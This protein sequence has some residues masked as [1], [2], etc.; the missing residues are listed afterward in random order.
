MPFNKTRSAGVYAKEILRVVNGAEL[1]ENAVVD[2][3]QIPLNADQRRILETGTVMIWTGAPGTSK[4]RP[5]PTSAPSNVNEVQTI[6][7]SA[8]ADAGAVKIKVPNYGTT[9]SIPFGSVT[10]AGLQAAIRA[11][12][13]GLNAMT[14]G[15]VSDTFTLTFPNLDIEPVSV[16][17]NTLKASSVNVTLTVGQGAQGSAALT[18]AA[19]AGI[20]MHT[21]EF[22]PGPDSDMDEKDDAPVALFTK[23][24]HFAADQLTGYANNS[25]VVKSAMTGAGND[26]CANCTF[27]S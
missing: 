26:R 20:V 21:T 24:C 9:A 3:N 11:I 1:A 19:I 8:T 18:A 6:V 17:S 15:L 13:T 4:V 14:V 16:E 5:I 10:A 22:W 23:N 25:T 7:R 27:Q 12:A 2:G